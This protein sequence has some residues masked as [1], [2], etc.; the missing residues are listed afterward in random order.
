MMLLTLS[1]QTNKKSRLSGK[2]GARVRGATV[3][4]KH[5][6]SKM[7]SPGVYGKCRVPE[8]VE[9]AGSQG[10]WKTQVARVCGKCGV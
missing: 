1:F 9:N 3:S 7:R 5:G 8:S 6:V 10:L 2:H 4:G